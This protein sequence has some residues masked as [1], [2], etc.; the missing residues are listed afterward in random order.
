M[1][2]F[3][4]AVVDLILVARTLNGAR[5]TSWDDH[6]GWSRPLSFLLSVKALVL[7]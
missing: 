7:T 6:L 2:D 3:V 5:F 1:A 4:I